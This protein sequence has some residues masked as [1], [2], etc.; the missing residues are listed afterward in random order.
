MMERFHA[1][2][3]KK[4]VPL[5]GNMNAKRFKEQNR[6]HQ[7]DTIRPVLLPHICANRYDNASGYSA[8][9]T[10][11]IL[12]ENSVRTI[13]WPA[14]RL[15]FKPIKPLQPNFGGAHECYSSDAIPHQYPYKYI[16]Y[17]NKGN[18]L[19]CNCHSR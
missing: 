16:S 19:C 3:Q 4:N 1:H 14:K 17:I 9:S 5:Q 6:T 15:E 13:Q 2:E 10:H 11:V 8:R 12:I 7:D 18:V